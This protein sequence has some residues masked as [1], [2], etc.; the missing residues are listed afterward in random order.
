MR[1]APAVAGGDVAG[2][3]AKREAA[4]VVGVEAEDGEAETEAEE[5]TGGEAEAE[6]EE[7]EGADTDCAELPVGVGGVGVGVVGEV[8]MP[9]MRPVRGP[10]ICADCSASATAEWTICCSADS[11]TP[12]AAEPTAGKEEDIAMGLRGGAKATAG[13]AEFE[14]SGCDC[15]CD[16]DWG[17][18]WAD[19]WAGSWDSC[20]CGA[21]RSMSEAGR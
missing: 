9:C 8:M 17:C 7:S 13:T 14:D 10:D 2:T 4:E 1:T 6:A 11:G 21:C 18:S 16:S 20:V 19:S 15:D 12:A 3:D 5:A